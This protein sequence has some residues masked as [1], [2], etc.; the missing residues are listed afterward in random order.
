MD[1]PAVKKPTRNL[2][3]L[4]PIAAR[5]MQMV[6]TDSVVFRQV[7]EL[8]RAD[9]AFSAEVLTLANSPLMGCRQ[10]I[11]SVLHGVA[12]LGLERVRGI[13]MTVA[14]RDFLSDGLQQPVLLR[15]WRH[16]IACALL[17]EQIASAAWMDKDKAYTAG[18]LHDAGRLGLLM[19]YPEDYAR[20]LE[21][22]DSSGRDTRV[23]ERGYFGVDHC[24]A[25]RDLAREWQLPAEFEEFAL[26]HH[27]PPQAAGFGNLELV[28]VACRLTDL[29]GFQVAGPAP[30]T[31]LDEI[32]YRL[33]ECA[34]GEMKSEHA[35]MMSIAAK[36]NSLECTLI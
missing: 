34:R 22:A 19:A 18:L 12:I 15:C 8:I 1:A 16:S 32:R 20:V 24:E 21:L 30:L 25:G 27:D 31:S 35:L 4:P 28:Q 36:I 6:S 17:C 10:E 5:L 2:Q 14:L 26:R 23:C 7:A 11:G 13:V 3:P 9:T 29:L 33:P